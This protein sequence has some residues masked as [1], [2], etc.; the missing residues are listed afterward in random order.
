MHI[1]LIYSIYLILLCRS[2]TS[3]TMLSAGR[4]SAV[5][6]GAARAFAAAAFKRGCATMPAAETRATEAATVN[7]IK[8]KIKKAAE[9][10]TEY[11]DLGISVGVI[12]AGFA[13][14]ANTRSMIQTLRAEMLAIKEALDGKINT[15]KEALEKQDKELE[16][17]IVASDAGTVKYLHK[18]AAYS[19]RSEKAFAQEGQETRR[20]GRGGAAEG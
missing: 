4:R 7:T 1:Q 10:A 2:T 11:K 8:G 20:I 13:Y 12:A 3:L 5:G 9:F 6:V 15:T 19:E 18:M 17:Q 14:A 16:K